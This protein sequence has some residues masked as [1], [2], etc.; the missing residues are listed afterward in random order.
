MVPQGGRQSRSPVSPVFHASVDYARAR[1]DVI[2]PD[3]PVVLI[4]PFFLFATVEEYH[5]YLA[6]DVKA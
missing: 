6:A 5:K 2:Q 1:L 4:V 3:S